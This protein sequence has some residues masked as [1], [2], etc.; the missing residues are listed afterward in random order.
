MLN[1]VTTIM[2]YGLPYKQFIGYCRVS[3][4][5]QGESGVGLARQR[6]SIEA[7]A[8]RHKAV[9]IE[10]YSDVASGMGDHLPGCQSLQKALEHA[11]RANS[12]ILVDRLDRLSRDTATVERMCR[13]HDVAIISA[14]DGGLLVDPA[15]L[16]SRAARAEEQGRLIGQRT[17]E[18]LRR[19]KKEGVRLGNTT[20]LPEAQRLGAAANQARSEAKASEIA[21]ALDAAGMGDAPAPAIVKLLNERAIRTSR[22]AAWTVAAVRRPLAQARQLIEERERRKL[23]SHPNFGIF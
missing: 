13:E 3:T 23:E 15:I 8:N 1:T 19:K 18:S 4:Q 9:L 21:D 17:K 12:P 11:A 22:G 7:F 5:R 10:V 2:A 6:A 16:E 14:S 20:N